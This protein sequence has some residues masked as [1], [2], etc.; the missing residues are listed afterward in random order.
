MQIGT[1]R[2]K[3]LPFA[4]VLINPPFYGIEQ[5]RNLLYFIYYDCFFFMPFH[6][7]IR[8]AYGGFPYFIIIKRE[9]LHLG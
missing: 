6:E 1:P 2:Q 9:A 4:A 7:P 5:L 3:I 8:I